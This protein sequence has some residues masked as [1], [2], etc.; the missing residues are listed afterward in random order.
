MPLEVAVRSPV[1][2]TLTALQCSHPTL[3]N[4]LPPISVEAVPSRGALDVDGL[5]QHEFLRS[6]GRVDHRCL[7]DGCLVTSGHCWPSAADEEWYSLKRPSSTVAVNRGELNAK[8]SAF[9]FSTFPPSLM[10]LPFLATYAP[11]VGL[12]GSSYHYSGRFLHL[13][14]VTM[15]G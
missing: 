6:T 2:Y 8:V 5:F 7:L 12:D 15:Q 9:F 13:G 1:D 4:S 11:Y 10:E 3:G 14:A